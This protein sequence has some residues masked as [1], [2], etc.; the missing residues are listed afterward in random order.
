METR[1]WF[2]FSATSQIDAGIESLNW[3]YVDA[4]ALQ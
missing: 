3:G 1:L 2:Y 4:Q